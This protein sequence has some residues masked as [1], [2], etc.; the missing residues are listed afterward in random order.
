[1]SDEPAKV[2]IFLDESGPSKQILVLDHKCN[3]FINIKISTAKELHDR[4]Y[5]DILNSYMIFSIDCCSGFN[6]AK[7]N[8]N[9]K[10]FSYTPRDIPILWA[11]SPK[12]VK[13][14]YEKVFIGFKNLK[15][16]AIKFVQY[17]HLE[18]NENESFINKLPNEIEYKQIEP[19]MTV[20]N[21][22]QS[23]DLHSDVNAFFSYME[24]NGIAPNSDFSYYSEYSLS[25]SLLYNNT[26]LNDDVVDVSSSSLNPH[27][28][29]NQ[30]QQQS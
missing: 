13:D 4:N 10:P 26:L 29:Q 19:S 25:T 30:E 16:K 1:M 28:I 8:K 20:N 17:N 24:E 27:Y 11:K 7:S 3:R 2:S 22:Y 21:I 9:F 15:P 18:K 23:E 14:E 12:D 5:K 6:L